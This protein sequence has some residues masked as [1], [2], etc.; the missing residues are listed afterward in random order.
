MVEMKQIELG[1][2]HILYDAVR[3][4]NINE[5]WFEP[6]YWQA[7][8]SVT[9]TAQGRA[10]TVFFE[11]QSWEY[12]LRHY[13]RGGLIAGFILDRYMWTGLHRTRA[14]Q[15]W[16]LLAQ[17]KQLGLPVPVPV[18]FRVQRT[19]LCYRADLIMEKIVN[20]S[21][22]ADSLSQAPVP[23]KLWRQIGSVIKQFHSAGVDHKDLNAHN[24]LLQDE[25][26]YLIDFDRGQIR[27]GKKHWQQRNLKRLLRSLKKLKSNRETF[28]FMPE[29]WQALLSG[30]SS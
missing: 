18:A 30:Y 27:A 3:Q 20:A 24:I 21:S 19:G 13:R 26:I 8:Q 11:Y 28:C 10:S 6:E 5:N 17:M 22:L 9:G 23:D 14:W 29:N 25:Q 12:V 2:Q 4:S 7:R 16:H 1:G 15:E